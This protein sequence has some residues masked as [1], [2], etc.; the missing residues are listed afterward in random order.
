MLRTAIRLEVPVLNGCEKEVYPQMKQMK[1][2]WKEAPEGLLSF[3]TSAPSVPSADRALKSSFA[4]SGTLLSQT[5]YLHL[6]TD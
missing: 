3:L 4:G 1:K 5:L 2:L 6:P